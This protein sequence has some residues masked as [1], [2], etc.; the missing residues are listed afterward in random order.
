MIQDAETKEGKS[1]KQKSD[2]KEIVKKVAKRYGVKYD[3]TQSEVK[4]ELN[5][6]EVRTVTKEGF[7]KAYK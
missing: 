1:M 4:V 7:L 5:N 6:G 3:E 2:V